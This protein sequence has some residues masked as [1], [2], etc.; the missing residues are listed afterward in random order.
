M[1][2]KD[3][4]YDTT[5]ILKINKRDKEL[6]EKYFKDVKGLPLSAGVRTVLFDYMYENEV[7][8]RDTGQSAA[9]RG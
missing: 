8:V 5:I 1:S 4:E 2:N 3:I 9:S 7:K 6:L